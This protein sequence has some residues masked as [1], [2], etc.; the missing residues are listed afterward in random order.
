MYGLLRLDCRLPHAKQV[1]HELKDFW[2]FVDNGDMVLTFRH[3]I[4][5]LYWLQIFWI[6]FS[7]L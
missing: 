7:L 3:L 4:D 6:K 1:L 5:Q 2:I